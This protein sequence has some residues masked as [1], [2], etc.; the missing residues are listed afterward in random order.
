M[1]TLTVKI[2]GLDRLSHGLKR[3]QIK[4]ILARVIRE[5][6]KDIKALMAAYPPEGPWNRPGP[7]PKRW[8]QRHKGPRWAR[9]EGGFGG[10]DTSEKLQK[11]WRHQSRG[12]YAKIYTNVT[13]APFVVSKEKQAWFHKR[14]GWHTDVDVVDEFKREKLDRRIELE[15]EKELKKTIE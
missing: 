1:T 2:E 9:K 3:M 8:Y 11:S 7:Y 14:H 12:L 4:R 5:A 13:Y 15:V 10:R 6:A